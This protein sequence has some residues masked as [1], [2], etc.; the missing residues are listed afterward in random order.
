MGTKINV[1]DW[2][3]VNFDKLCAIAV[4][5][6]HVLGLDPKDI[7][8]VRNGGEDLDIEGDPADREYWKR[9]GRSMTE[10]LAIRH[11]L[12]KP[13][14]DG[15]KLLESGIPGLVPLCQALAQN[16]GK[17]QG[18]GGGQLYQ[19]GTIPMIARNL[20]MLPEQAPVAARRIV[21]AVA[22]ALKT[23]KPVSSLV[24]TVAYDAERCWS[25]INE[26]LAKA[27][28]K[29]YEEANLIAASL[30]S[31]SE[32][33]DTRRFP[34]ATSPDAEGLEVRTV[35][36]NLMKHLWAALKNIEALRI[37]AAVVV[38]PETG[39]IAVL[40][41]Q[42]EKADVRPVLGALAKRFPGAEFDANFDRGSL[43]WDPRFSKKPGPDAEA[44]VEAV[45]GQLLVRPPITVQPPSFKMTLG[46]RL[47][48][49]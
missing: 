24:E 1:R 23:G 26:D 39:R 25:A 19:K 47:R 38:N 28:Y 32:R 21:A 22:K 11:G 48:T 8:F 4:E 40:T 5:I 3:S 45:S 12:G 16:H 6:V 10:L 20:A 17:V 2:E 13:D 34:L 31:R 41:S 14:L 42:Q 36:P 27:E 46:D 33:A 35:N 15:L 29:V 44:V 9:G 43:V 37:A 7:E 49:R 18:K 30:A